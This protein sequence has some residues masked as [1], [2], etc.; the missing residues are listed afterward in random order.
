VAK[1]TKIGAVFESGQPD[2][3]GVQAAVFLRLQDFY[4]ALPIAMIISAKQ[5]YFS[6]IIFG[7]HTCNLLI[8]K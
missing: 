6:E 7:K 1:A 3:S 4:G 8:K 5:V 2:L